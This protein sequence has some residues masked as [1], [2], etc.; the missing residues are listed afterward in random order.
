MKL[1]ELKGDL[2][3]ETKFV[4]FTPCGHDLG[5]PNCE[6]TVLQSAKQSKIPLFQ[7]NVSNRKYKLISN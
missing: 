7:C 5:D 6:V 4:C 1:S 3:N 2:I